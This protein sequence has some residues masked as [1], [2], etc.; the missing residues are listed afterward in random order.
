M[1]KRSAIALVAAM[2]VAHPAAAAPQ[3][4]ILDTDFTTIG[5]DGKVSPA[6]SVHEHKGSSV[7]KS[8]QEKPHAHSIYPDPS[9]KFAVSAD[10]GLDQVLVYALDPSKGAIV[11]AVTPFASQTRKVASSRA[12]LR[13]TSC[14]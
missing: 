1:V 4:I 7:D 14:A 5:D 2:F 9:N 3:K 11:P 6:V 12:L 8:R 10:L 13:A